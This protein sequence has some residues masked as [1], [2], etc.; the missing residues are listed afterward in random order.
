MN[1]QKESAEPKPEKASTS[2]Q[3]ASNDINAK[4]DS[5]VKKKDEHNQPPWELRTNPVP[6]IVRV[7]TDEQGRKHTQFIVGEMNTCGNVHGLPNADLIVTAV[8][9]HEKLVE[10]LREIKKGE[11]AFSRDQLT[12][13]NNT[14]ENMK[15]IADQALTDAERK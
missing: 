14:I 1:Q 12:H 2:A 15:E 7:F 10:A 13:A 11:G 8:N 6:H 3:T 9:N 4:N 5:N